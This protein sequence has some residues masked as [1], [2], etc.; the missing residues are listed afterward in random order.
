MVL[1]I[2]Y[3]VLGIGYWVMGNGY[4]VG[5]RTGT[6]NVLGLAV[7]KSIPWL[8]VLQRNCSRRTALNRD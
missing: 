2:G 5:G 6:A 3:W 7:G 1:G 4:L 8:V